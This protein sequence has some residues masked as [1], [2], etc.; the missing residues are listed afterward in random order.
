MAGIPWRGDEFAAQA[1]LALVIGLNRA[2]EYARGRM[3]PRM[4]IDTGAMRG[5]TQTYHARPTS[6]ES[7]VTVNTPYAVKQH[8][9]LGYFHAE[10]E[11]KFAERTF[12]DEREAMLRLIGAPLGT[13]R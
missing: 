3:L 10:G 5:S 9:E 13:I 6:L 11:A 7:G 8:E 12:R 2:A 4:P 1:T